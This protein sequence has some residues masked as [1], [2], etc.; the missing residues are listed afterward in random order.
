MNWCFIRSF[1]AAFWCVQ[2]ELA[3]AH[4]ASNTLEAQLN[5]CA[6]ELQAS[7]HRMA[8]MEGHIA[9]LQHDMEYLAAHKDQLVRDA[10]VLGA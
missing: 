7:Q 8:S 9:Q 3:S 2:G 6:E 10:V 5:E 1:S 4:E